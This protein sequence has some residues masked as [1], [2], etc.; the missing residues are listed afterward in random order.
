MSDETQAEPSPDEQNH[1][2]RG[3]IS[4]LEEEVA[5]VRRS[6]ENAEM[7][8]KAYQDPIAM[9]RHSMDEAPIG[10]ALYS[11]EMRYRVV[12]KSLAQMNGIPAED[13][14]GR[15]VEE[16]VPHRASLLR[17]AF[18][19][20]TETRRPLLNWETSYETTAEPREV[21]YYTERWY[22]LFTTEG[23]IYAVYC[24]VTD[25]TVQK[26]AEEELL[27]SRERLE[28]AQSSG[29]IATYDWN[30]RENV[31]HG[32][33]EFNPLYGLPPSDIGPSIEE[34][35][36]LIHPE[37]RER[38]Q[39]EREQ[40]RQGGDPCDSE[41]RVVWPDGT[42]HWLLARGKLLR[43]S[44]GKPIRMVGVNMDIT[45][46]KRAEAALATS[47]NEIRALAGNLLTAQ[48]DEHRKLYR[49][50]H[51]QICQDLASIAIELGGCAAKPPPREDMAIRLKALQTRVIQAASDTR[52]IALQLHSPVLDDLGLVIALRE[53]CQQGSALA[54]G[55]AFEFESSAMPEVVPP[56]VA[57]CAY[58]VAQES[59]RNIAKHSGAR[60]A[61][62]ALSCSNRTIVLTI[63]DDGI[64]FDP[65]M[66]R[67]NGGLGLIGMEER[68]R[69]VNGKLTITAQPVSGTRVVLEV[70]MTE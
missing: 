38:V 33:R 63:S 31:G 10:F 3:R 9:L 20:V 43:D 5:R 12:N 24:S 17:E 8:L 60:H 61:W 42:V 54:P 28:L 34:W 62:V 23:R 41:F 40:T 1:Q 68:V 11:D 51:D 4:E 64:G 57:S 29:G 50:V 6:L 2:L 22:P 66:T 46:R 35:L 26:R 21:R 49:E 19:Q 47:H 36:Q 45:E 18:R 27:V 52:H 67:G 56:E 53:L 25:I 69:S 55:I 14:I 65:R 44:E 58:H 37:D 48:E 39:A 59:I 16:V 32:S 13:H 15:T 7:A 30:L 70:P